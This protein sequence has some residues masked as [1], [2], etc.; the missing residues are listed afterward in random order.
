MPNSVNM[1][2]VLL[3]IG[4]RDG[5]EGFEFELTLLLNSPYRLG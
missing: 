4:R 5:S 1:L 2:R 3:R